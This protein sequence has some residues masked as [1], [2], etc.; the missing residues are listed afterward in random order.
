[1]L[2]IFLLM[3]FVFV[4]WSII[5]A[6]AKGNINVASAIVDEFRIEEDS[7]KPKDPNAPKTYGKAIQSEVKNK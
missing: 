7:D 6:A 2:G 3:I 1:M 4:F 5:G